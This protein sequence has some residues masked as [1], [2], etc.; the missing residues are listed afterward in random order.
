MDFPISIDRTSLFQILGVLGGIFHFYSNSNRKLCEQ[1]VDT[2]VRCRFFQHLIWVCTVCLCPTNMTLGL[3]GLDVSKQLR[4]L[5]Y[6]TFC[7]I[8]SGAA[9]YAYIQ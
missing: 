5:P 7:G 4:P 3:Y 9:L 8:C 1:T 2:L 6:A